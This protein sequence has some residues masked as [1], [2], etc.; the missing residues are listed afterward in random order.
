MAS[1]RTAA[2]RGA[3]HPGGRDTPIPREAAVGDPRGRKVQR[4]SWRAKDEVD[5]LLRRSRAGTIT[6][7][8][9]ETGLK[10]VDAALV[11]MLCMVRH[12]L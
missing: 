5:N 8:D 7:L 11:R 1:N 3:G 2:R 9:L 10:E 6:R 4:Q 12:Y